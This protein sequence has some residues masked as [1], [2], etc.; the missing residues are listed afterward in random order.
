MVER[1]VII[2]QQNP[3]DLL[4]PEGWIG[5]IKRKVRVLGEKAELIDPTK[6]DEVTMLKGRHYEEKEEEKALKETS[7]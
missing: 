2:K 6:F 4:L 1:I 5:T 3:G 7:F